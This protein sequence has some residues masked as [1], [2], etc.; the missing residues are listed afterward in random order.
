M[1]NQQLWAWLVL[2]GIITL[3]AMVSG[4][5]FERQALTIMAGGMMT[6]VTAVVGWM[7]AVRAGDLRPEETDLINTSAA[8]PRDLTAARFARLMAVLWTW[9]GVAMLGCYYLTDLSWQHAWQ[10]GAGMLLIGGLVWMYGAARGRADPR[11]AT[12]DRAL[13]ARWLTRLQGIAILAGLIFLM[14]GDKL[15][16]DKA[17]WAANVV[18]VA[19]GLGLYALSRAALQAEDRVARAAAMTG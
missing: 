14:I 1:T 10:Y 3:A 12:A 7:F 5:A 17:D 8:G 2:T 9:S 18:F 11:F 4:I 15:H 19:G 6:V 13:A 16:A